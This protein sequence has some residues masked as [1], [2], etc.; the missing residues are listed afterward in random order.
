MRIRVS[1]LAAAAGAIWFYL[2]RE[3]IFPLFLLAAVLHEGA[4]L[5]A[6]ALFQGQIPK[7][8]RLHLG[9][10]GGEIFTGLL[11]PGKEAVAIAAG[12]LSNLAVFFAVTWAS[13]HLFLPEKLLIF[14]GINLVLGA[15]NLLP[16][17]CLD[18]GRLVQLGLEA[19]LSYDTAETV[20]L[21]LSFLVIA[22]M[23]SLGLLLSYR[24][25]A[26]FALVLSASWLALKH[27]SC[28]QEE[29]VLK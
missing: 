24:Y 11:S 8:S 3:G 10:L 2:D 7:N 4:H 17:L 29:N 18:G 13:H 12:P 1:P 23:G 25:G 27:L 20:C 16:V 19:F 9:L 14:A 6:L 5:L 22:L 21:V 26:G 15:Y 28:I